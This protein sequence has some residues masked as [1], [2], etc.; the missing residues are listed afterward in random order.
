MQ[1]RG[2]NRV[3]E[4][5]VHVVSKRRK[6]LGVQAHHFLSPVIWIERIARSPQRLVI[7]S[8]RVTCNQR[9]V[10]HVVAILLSV[11]GSIVL[12][13]DRFIIQL[14]VRREV[15]LN[16]ESEYLRQW[17]NDTTAITAKFFLFNITNSH[18]IESG[19]DADINVREIPAI[20][21]DVQRQRKIITMNDSA[22]EYQ[23]ISFFTFNPN[24]SESSLEQLVHMVNIPLA[25]I[26][27]NAGSADKLVR[28]A[29]SVLA[30]ASGSHVFTQRSANEILFEGYRD[31]LFALVKAVEQR[32]RLPGA[33]R[34][35]DVF[36]LMKDVSHS[37]T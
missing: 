24:L 21:Y 22:I 11:L 33:D 35:P 17:L 20:V 30:R 12:F 8:M 28:R 13:A 6:K 15:T 4:C 1:R 19:E 18:L 25:V 16:N 9:L 36:S 2:N 14:E 5:L 27:R 3:N 37:I 32:A 29:S 31:P 7:S 23:P 34:I 10:W 26:M